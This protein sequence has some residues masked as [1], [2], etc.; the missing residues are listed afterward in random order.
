M[1]FM[2]AMTIGYTIATVVDALV[3]RYLIEWPRE[4]DVIAFIASRGGTKVPSVELGKCYGNRVYPVLR[5]LA[6][7]G[8][9]V[10]DLESD[11][12]RARARYFYGFSDKLKP[13]PPKFAS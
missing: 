3:W 7:R 5:R 11:P 2:A 6:K 4:G 8:L 12:T 13:P 10:C 9:L 1:K